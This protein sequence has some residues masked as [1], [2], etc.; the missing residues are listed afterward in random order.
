M[1]YS[2]TPTVAVLMST[3]NGEKF[4]RE[5]L[6]SIFSQ[7]GVDVKIYARDDGSTDGTVDILKEYAQYKPVIIFQDGEN[8]GPGESFMRLVYKYADEPGI[9]FYAFAD[10]DDIWLENKLKMA[11]HNIQES[12]YSGPILYSS[13]QY[14]YVDGENKG[15]RYKE[16]QK[17]DLIPH[18]TKNT[19]SGCTFVFNKELAQL[20]SNSDKPDQRIVKYRLHDAWIMLVAILCGHVLYDQASYMFYRIHS[21]NVVGV[22]K[23]SLFKRFRKFQRFFIER[24][25]ANLRML[26]AEQL[27][28][29]F[30]KIKEEDKKVLKLY[31]DY[32]KNWRNKW[33][34]ALNREIR[35][36]CAENPNVFT[37]KVLLNFV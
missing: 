34:L 5:Q 29:S 2:E 36:N 27:I 23:E 1:N 14:L 20:L 10:Q 30:P 15:Y 4:I 6:E 33:K 17:I 26:T 8:V 19:I 35:A 28:K 13:N 24:D 21:F 9:E 32:Q 7:V 3:Y 16:R 12:T 25:D 31:A 22:K 37:I 11:V 18:I